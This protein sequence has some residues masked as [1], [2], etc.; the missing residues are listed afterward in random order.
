[1]NIEIGSMEVKSAHVHLFLRA[2]LIYA[3]HCIVR[4]MKGYISRI[5]RKEFAPSPDACHAWGP[6]AEWQARGSTDDAG[7]ITLTIADAPEEWRNET[8]RIQSTRWSRGLQGRITNGTTMVQ[9]GENTLSITLNNINLEE[10]P[11]L[12]FNL[13]GPDSTVRELEIELRD[14]CIAKLQETYRED[15]I[16]DLS[17]HNDEVRKQASAYQKP[18]TGDSRA[19]AQRTLH[20]LHETTSRRQRATN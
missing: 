11:Q 12:H 5:L 15:Q 16:Q 10:L 18:L 14:I 7:N 2:K 3:P 4:Q 17:K 19:E 9:C 20:A 13:Q 6:E 1:M 8:C